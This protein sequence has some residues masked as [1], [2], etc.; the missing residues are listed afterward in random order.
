MRFT[1]TAIKKLKPE[2]KRYEVWETNGKGFGLRVSPA[3]RKSWIFIYRYDGVPRRMTLGT[4][5]EMS[6]ATAHETLA[7]SRGVINKGGDPGIEKL[8]KK[9]ANR[10]A[11]TVKDLVEEY[12]EKWAKVRKKER[13]WKEDQRMLYKD[14]VPA[15]GR[16]KA[17]DIKRRDIIVLLDQ[18]VERGATVG[19]NRTL[20]VIRRMFNFAVERSILDASPCV[21]IPAPAKENRR[22][23]VL[24]EGEIKLFWGGLKNARMSPGTRLVLKLQLATIQRKGEVVEAA[25]DDF[26]LKNGWWTIPGEKTKN[27]LPHRVPLNNIALDLLQ[28]I[29]ELSGDNNCLFP[30]PKGSNHVSDTSIDHAVRNNLEFFKMDGFVPHDL[31]RSGASH[32][33]SMGIPR[34]VVG[35][36]LNHA[37]R[38]VTSVYDRHSYDS[39][40]RQ[41]MDTWGRKLESIITGESS[42]KIIE[43]K[44]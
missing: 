36:I 29:K 13:S 23:R 30:S 19:A 20:A 6:L 32:L 22:D 5:P 8:H 27:K 40:K 42:G 41:A 25:W 24:S 33:T 18:L 43:L 34:L 14:L 35:R 17:K 44:R 7:R 1:D 21:Q 2:L 16:R 15:Y 12:L 10:A 11:F 28:E 39:E 9:S 31:R 3:G 4:Y 38:S 26:D 37:E